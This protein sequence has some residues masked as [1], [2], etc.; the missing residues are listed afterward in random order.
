MAQRKYTVGEIER[1]RSALWQAVPA[2]LPFD[3]VQ[4]SAEIEH[5][6]Q[7]YMAN[8]TDPSE[9]ERPIYV[10]ANNVARFG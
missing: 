10:D 9:L 4:K 5:Q 3:G 6:I 7:T 2:G 8:G 1:M